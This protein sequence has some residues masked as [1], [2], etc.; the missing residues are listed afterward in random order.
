MRMDRTDR[1]SRRATRRVATMAQLRDDSDDPKNEAEGKGSIEGAQGSTRKTTAHGQLR[2]SGQERRRLKRRTGF[3]KEQPLEKVSHSK[4]GK[5]GS[6]K[7]AALAALHYS[8]DASGKAGLDLAG[9]R[10]FGRG[11]GAFLVWLQ[12]EG[13]G[14][15]VG[16]PAGPK[17][18][19][20]YSNKYGVHSA[21]CLRMHPGNRQPHLTHA[22][23]HALGRDAIL[24]M[25]HV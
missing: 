19:T 12:R 11:G 17:H 23:T 6:K 7:L 13:L 20:P 8:R 5:V 4:V 21:R 14:S 24:C 15:P 18:S 25:V 9:M 1:S 16:P 10:T 22:R 3:D 2:C